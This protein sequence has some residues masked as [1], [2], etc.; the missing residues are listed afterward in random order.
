MNSLLLLRHAKAVNSQPGQTDFD[1]P[2]N[3]RGMHD[4]ATVGR[5]LASLGIAFNILSSPAV[6]ARQTTEVIMF[7][8]G[9]ETV[10]HYDPR[11][12]EASVENLV[13]VISE[14]QN[15]AATLLLVGHN[16]GIERLL[17]VLTG[18]EIAMGTARLAKIRI[19]DWHEVGSSL[20]QLDQ[21]ISPKEIESKN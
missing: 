19:D 13:A 9:A 16:P 2:L 8:T 3:E 11:I 6:R 7:S 17:K 4:S 20:Y 18:Q 21:I 15:S 10:V 12:Y 14:F 1:R 5:Y